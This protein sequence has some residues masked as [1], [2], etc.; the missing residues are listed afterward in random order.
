[1][2]VSVSAKYLDEFVCHRCH[3]WRDSLRLGRNPAP[4]LWFDCLEI[5]WKAAFPEYPLVLRIEFPGDLFPLRIEHHCYPLVLWIDHPEA[6]F[7]LAALLRHK[8]NHPNCTHYCCYC[9]DVLNTNWNNV[10][11]R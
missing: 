9:H 7:V 6:P 4:H 11:A 1:M 5:V 3:A 2:T 10:S 8:W